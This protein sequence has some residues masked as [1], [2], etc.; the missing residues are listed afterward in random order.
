[1]Q[2]ATRIYIKILLQIFPGIHLRELQRQIGI[3]FN[4]TR[5]HVD[6]L[7]KDNELLRVD[8][9][10]YSRLYPAQIERDDIVLFAAIRNNIDKRILHELDREGTCS[11]E[12]LRRLTGLAKSTLSE[13]LTKLRSQG[14]LDYR[15]ISGVYMYSLRNT[16]KVHLALSEQRP[17]IL[18]QAGERFAALWDF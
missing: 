17:R 6:K 15:A 8:D 11:S 18:G 2:N 1:M 13:H 12:Y 14:I 4:S 7:S 3:S 16:E 9:R 5:Y 10:R